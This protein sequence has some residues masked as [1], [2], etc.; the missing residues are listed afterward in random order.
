[1][2]HCHFSKDAQLQKSR[3]HCLSTC[4][5]LNA[6]V[7]PLI[8]TQLFTCWE[9]LS[10]GWFPRSDTVPMK[11]IQ[12]LGEA[13]TARGEFNRAFCSGACRSVICTE[14]NTSI[15]KL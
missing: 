8:S 4:L 2:E 12:Y 6:S 7:F 9:T 3:H 5:I 13:V 15:V 1:M 14:A 11:S 10:S